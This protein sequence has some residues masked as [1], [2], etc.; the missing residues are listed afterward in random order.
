MKVV[1]Y[2][3][4]S[5]EKELLAKAN[6]KKHDITLIAN[7]LT[8]ETTSYAEGK[9][10]VVVFTSDDVSASVIQKLAHYG[11]KYIA[12]R[13][14]GTDHIDKQA[15]AAANIKIAN[16]P[17]Y[18]PHSIA[19]H[20]LTLVLALNRKILLSTER[21]KNFDFRL[22]GLVGFTLY[23][24]TVGIIGLGE[25]GLITAKI[26][27]GFGCKVLAYDQVKHQHT[28]IKHVGL[29]EL[30]AKSDIISLHVPL[31]DE[32]RHIINAEHLAKMKT[33]V[34]L[35]NTGRGG[36]LNT[37]DVLQAL[38]SGKIGALGADVYEYEHGLFFEN[39]HQD[40]QKDCLLQQLLAFP[41]VMITPHQAFLTK[42]ALQEIAQLTI[43]SLD[44]WQENKCVGKAC[45]C[46][47]NC[48]KEAAK[49]KQLSPHQS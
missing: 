4:R 5:F 14:V 7:P 39:H 12:T 13:S 38:K 24:K 26:F 44:L 19:E 6:Q 48:Q 11:V 47:K 16:I 18:S 42:E 35:I 2:S 1:V 49:I 43:K 37:N 9:D 3:T 41:N 34:M 29:E 30:Y 31:T 23:G 22:D 15:A 25:I 10:A 33:G 32:T 45:A 28:G 17:S 40:K 36:L 8:D 20:V 46:A 27:N 21:S